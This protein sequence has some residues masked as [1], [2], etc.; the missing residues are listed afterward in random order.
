MTSI[1]PR[2]TVES[3]H[4]NLDEEIR[5]DPVGT[6]STLHRFCLFSDNRQLLIPF[7]SSNLQ[8]LLASSDEQVRHYSLHIA[9]LYAHDLPFIRHDDTSLPF[10]SLME[11]H[12]AEQLCVILSS[13]PFAVQTSVTSLVYWLSQ[14]K[15]W[16]QKLINAGIVSS[17]KNI[18]QSGTAQSLGNLAQQVLDYITTC[19]ASFEDLFD[20]VSSG[21][22]L[23][24]PEVNY[25]DNLEEENFGDEVEDKEASSAGEE[26]AKLDVGAEEDQPCLEAGKHAE[27]QEF[28]EEIPGEELVEEELVEEEIHEEELGEE[29]LVEEEIHGEELVEE[30]TFKDNL[31]AEEGSLQVVTEPEVPI[32]D[33]VVDVANVDEEIDEVFQSGSLSDEEAVNDLESGELSN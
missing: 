21:V 10:E 24:V 5:N 7:V 29:E 20:L 19:D 27:L 13:A 25:G 14:R 4:S 22:K 6:M 9:S 33:D 26:Q 28:E 30:E 18:V 3:F 8:H 1:Y 15:Q 17:L 23:E 31:L 2:E 16:K 12:F 32:M 11:N